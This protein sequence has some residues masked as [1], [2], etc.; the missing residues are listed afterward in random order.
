MIWGAVGPQ[1]MFSNGG[2][3]SATLWGFLLGA[4]LPIPFYLLAKRWPGSILRYVHIPVVL[5]GPLYLAP[6]NFSYLWPG[7]MFGYLFN[8]H[9]KQRYTSWWQKYALPLTTGFQ[10]A[11]ALSAI[12]IF[13]AVQ[14]KGIN[15]SWWGNNVSFAGVD[16]SGDCVLLTPPANGTF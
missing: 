4:L 7:V 12:V 10:V 13:F 5:S 1:R 8:V 15:L 2:Y 6:Y 11:I 14:Y 16:G 9:I 3:Y